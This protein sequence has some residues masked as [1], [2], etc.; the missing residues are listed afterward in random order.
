ME[1]KNLKN[2]YI[3]MKNNIQ[4][5][6]DYINGEYYYY[7][8]DTNCGD[9]KYKL[10]PVSVCWL[11]ENSCNLNCIYCFA[12]NKNNCSM[13]N[14]KNVVDNILTLDPLTIILTGGEPTL[15]KKIGGI[16]EYIGD[17]AFTIIDSNGTTECWEEI[18]P[19]LKNSLVRF[20]IDSLNCDII[21][22]VRPSKIIDA[23]ENQIEII[24]KNIK[25][26]RDNNIPVIIQTVMTKYNTEELEEIYN[27]LL[28]L[29]VQRWY[30]SAVK[31]SDK[32]KN[33]YNDICLNEEEIEKVK[34]KIDK[35][36]TDKI[37]IT[38]SLEKNAGAR[39][40]LFIEKSGKFFVDTIKDGIRYIGENPTMENVQS[41]LDIDEHHN[42]Y[43]KKKNIIKRN[44]K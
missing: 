41:E 11:I 40:R 35:F 7:Y 20:S 9:I 23:T 44:I 38:F 29:G 33:N 5:V 27:Y 15:N 42:L 2:L 28:E 6:Y 37:N 39:A 14:Y 1:V 19:K 22:I 34:E 3:K 26:L 24:T 16:I 4:I 31:Y 18:I 36:N 25:L 12:E 8:Q 13:A 10:S 32:C 21:K 30:I 17:K 43:I